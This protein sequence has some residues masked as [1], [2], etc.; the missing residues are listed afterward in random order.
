[1]TN[2]ASVASIAVGHHVGGS[3]GVQ[4]LQMI[5]D[6]LG[7]VRPFQCERRVELAPDDI[8]LYSGDRREHVLFVHSGLIRVQHID[9]DGRRHILNLCGSGEFLGVNPN[10]RNGCSVEASIPSVLYRINRQSFDAAF[11]QNEWFRHLIHRQQDLKLERLRFLA[12]ML[13]TL[14]PFERIS[15]FLFMSTHFLPTHIAVD[16]SL[17]LRLTLPRADMA[18][19]LGT[20]VETI[21]RVTQQLRRDGVI[22][23]MDPMHFRIPDRRTLM[24][25]GRVDNRVFSGLGLTAPLAMVAVGA[26]I[27]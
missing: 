8:A 23:I 11:T 10:D 3:D 25:L 6:A 13:C 16:G 14:R 22:E 15:A 7:A 12:W 5:R 9:P 4:T 21:S 17:H 27:H 1:M 20:S 19:L 18:D 24:S 26:A 2:S